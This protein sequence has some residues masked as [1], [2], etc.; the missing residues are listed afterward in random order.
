MQLREKQKARRYYGVLEKQFRSYYEKASRQPGITGENL[1]RLL[2]CRLDNVARPARLRGLAPR[3]RASSSAT[4]TGPST[5][6]A[7]NIPSY[8][9]RAGDVIAIKA[10]TTGQQVIRDATELTGQVP[11]WLQA[12]HESSPAKVLRKPERARDRGPGAGA[13]DRRAVLEV[14]DHL[15]TA[16]PGA[17]ARAA[18]GSQEHARR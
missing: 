5:A 4:A 10:A 3:R 18:V 17:R 6:A 14:I 9:V 13:A 1:L 11:A 7:S 16:G 8:Q 15:R 2:E 12:D